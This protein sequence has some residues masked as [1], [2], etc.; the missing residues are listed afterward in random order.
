MRSI[1]DQ[2]FIMRCMTVLMSL[3]LPWV[4][5]QGAYSSPALP[6][7]SQSLPRSK[8]A[9][10]SGGLSVGLRY[11]PLLPVPSYMLSFSLQNPSSPY[12]SCLMNSY[13]SFNS[14]LK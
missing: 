2:N 11:L 1:V 7:S 4:R 3:L 13:S 9:G 8:L 14:W 5:L 12:F 6:F 10:S